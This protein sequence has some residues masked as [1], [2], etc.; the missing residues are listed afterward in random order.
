MDAAAEKANASLDEA[1]RNNKELNDE[2][3]RLK[4]VIAEQGTKIEDDAKFRDAAIEAASV[5]KGRHQVE[6]EMAVAAAKV[7]L[8]DLLTGK[9]FREIA[10]VI[11]VAKEEV[12][13]ARESTLTAA[14]DAAKARESTLAAAKDKAEKDAAAAITK[15]G[16]ET[17][18]AIAKHGEEIAAM[19]AHEE[20]VII[21]RDVAVRDAAA[22]AEMVCAAETE[23]STFKERAAA[24]EKKMTAR[25]AEL[26]A[27]K[28]IAE[29]QLVAAKDKA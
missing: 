2:L 13:K 10:V 19:K 5:M 29:G 25:E 7:E 15:N 24:V 21:A 17:A 26:V 1:Q 12:A 22:A 11:E 9:Y 4:G 20:Q 14:N 28:Q 8:H 3:A 16:E 6:K 18:A 27:A 23:I